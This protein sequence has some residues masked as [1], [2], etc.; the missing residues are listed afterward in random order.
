[1][2]GPRKP[3]Y[4]RTTRNLGA[5]PGLSPSFLRTPTPEGDPGFSPPSFPSII[6]PTPID[7]GMSA[8][9][10]PDPRRPTIGRD[11]RFPGILGDDPRH[12]MLTAGAA[13][14]SSANHLHD[15]TVAAHPMG[16]KDRLYGALEAAGA[17]GTLDPNADSGAES[18]LGSALRSFAAG[19]G[20]QRQM[21]EQQAAAQE[22]ATHEQATNDELRARA[23][24]Y[25]AQAGRQPAGETQANRI[26]LENI[27]QGHFLERIRAA[28]HVAAIRAQS[29]GKL[30]PAQEE[31][32]RRYQGANTAGQGAVERAQGDVAAG[33]RDPL[34]PGQEDQIRT[35]TRHG[36]NP[37]YSADSTSVVNDIN[38]LLH[39]GLPRTVAPAPS[40]DPLAPG[41]RVRDILVRYLQSQ[42]KSVAP[43][44]PR[45]ADKLSL[46]A[47][48]AADTSAPD[49]SQGT[50]QDEPQPDELTPDEIER[51]SAMVADLDEGDARAELM[52]AGYGPSQVNIILTHQ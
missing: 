29:G 43:A 18:F 47:G 25:R 46:P 52:A 13:G 38:P 11:R 30:T 3:S 28:A 26:E 35:A 51:A 9:P 14:L 7:P 21:S 44:A 10:F 6:Q 50:S 41:S 2:I 16:I 36:V 20:A 23:E 45:A 19:R 1:M 37:D 49:A 8:P 40:T 24:Y 33:R 32:L 34:V 12:A 4:L 17:A 31:V 15:P 27:R 48:P 22:H 5:D 42:N 39:P